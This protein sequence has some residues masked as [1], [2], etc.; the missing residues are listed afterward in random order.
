ML[1]SWEQHGRQR[2]AD[3]SECSNAMLRHTQTGSCFPVDKGACPLFSYFEGRLLNLLV[4]EN[5]VKFVR[6]VNNVELRQTKMNSTIVKSL[7]SCLGT[8]GVKEKIEDFL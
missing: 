8:G 7:T 6:T 4:F 2:L 3:Q 1:D 5:K